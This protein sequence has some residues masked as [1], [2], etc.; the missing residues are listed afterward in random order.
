MGSRD[1]SEAQNCLQEC[2]FR[3]FVPVSDEVIR[4]HLRGNDPQ[5]YCRRGR[6]IGV[7]PLL[8]DETCCF[9]AVDFDKN[10]MGR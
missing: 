9:L 10:R 8:T 3:T 5:E 7:Y 4:N 1:L 6:K 2:N